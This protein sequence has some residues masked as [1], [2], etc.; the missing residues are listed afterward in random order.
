MRSTQPTATFQDAWLMAT[1]LPPEQRASLAQALLHRDANDSDKRRPASRVRKGEPASKSLTVVLV[2][3]EQFATK[4]Q[5]RLDDLMS[6][7]SEGLLMPREREELAQLV[8]RYEQIMLANSEA[9]LRATHPMLFDGKR[10]LVS[11][12]ARRVSQRGRTV[13]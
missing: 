3:L 4:E 11:A 8:D 7:N 9:L 6:R 2:A 13:A 12:R 1:Q 5:I 10:R